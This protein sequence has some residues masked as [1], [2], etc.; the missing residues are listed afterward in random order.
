MT[1]LLLWPASSLS[2]RPVPFANLTRSLTLLL[3]SLLAGH[4]GPRVGYK[5][6]PVWHLHLRQRPRVDHGIFLDDP[7]LK[8]QPGDH[9][10]DFIGVERT[11]RVERHRSIDEI[12]Q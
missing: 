10:V 7:I 8:Q 11:R 9:R 4:V 3:V 2:P 6:V 12:V 1:S 5:A